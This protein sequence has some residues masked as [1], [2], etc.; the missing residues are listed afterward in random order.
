M[1]LTVSPPAPVLIVPYVWIGDFVRC[2]SVVKLLRAQNPDMPVDLLSSS[3]CVPLADY[4]PGVRKA[5]VFDLPRGSL[6]LSRHRALSRVLRQEYYVQAL[7]MPRTWKSALAPWLAGIP[8]RTGFI[9]E[10]RYGLINDLRRGERALPRMID[11]I[12][13]LALR[14]DEPPPPNWPLPELQVPPQE[15]EQWRAAR[16]LKKDGRPVVALAPGAVGQGKAWPSRL[17][18]ELARRLAKDG[19]AI[20]VIGSAKEA[21]LA[22]EIAVAGGDAVHDLT[23]DD[24]RSAVRA[25]AAA[26]VAVT[27]DSGP[28]HIA[29]ALGTRTVAIF[30]PSDPKLWAPLN[31]LAA[32]LEPSGAE[33][34][35]TGVSV[36][37]VYGAVRAATAR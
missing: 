33:R 15:I 9:G 21:P 19:N 35:T 8:L 36:E 31:P 3:L 1:A 22:A 12:S 27:N 37:R 5:L 34:T 30:G 17:Y 24:L 32:L 14:Q 29:A 7:V 4:M 18:A 11:R 23:V 25:L 6:A 26:D 16:G 20:W 10:M 2:H 13:A 28:M